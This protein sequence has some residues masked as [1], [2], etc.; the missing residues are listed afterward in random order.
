MHG[1]DVVKYAKLDNNHTPT[2]ILLLVPSK[3]RKEKLYYQFYYTTF[4]GDAIALSVC[5]KPLNL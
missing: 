1:N 5:N 3:T 2:L 4:A